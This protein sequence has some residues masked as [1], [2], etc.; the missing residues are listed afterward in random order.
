MKKIIKNFD[1]FKIINFYVGY[2][3]MGTASLMLIPILTS[4]IFKEWS[5]LLDFIISINIALSLGIFLM[6]T[7]KSKIDKVKVQWKHGL[8]IASSSWIIL[9]LLC[10]VPYE[11]SGNT[12]IFLRCMF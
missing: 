7:G 5:A 12:V 2:V 8:I 3:I 9:T 11:L 1:D 10:A 6:F 4:L